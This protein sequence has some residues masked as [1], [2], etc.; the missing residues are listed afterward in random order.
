MTN[1]QC[2]TRT[3]IMSAVL[4]ILFSALL[5]PAWAQDAKQQD[6]NHTKKLP[7]ASEAEVKKVKDAMP[8]Q[9]AVTPKAKRRIL[10]FD[11]CEG[12]PHSCIPLATATFKIMGEKTGAFQADSAS[13][14]KVFTK[15]NLAKYDAVLF[16]NTTH[17]KF[18]D[19]A[20]REALMAFIKGGKGIIGIHA[21]TDNFYN[22]PEAAAMMGGVFD[23]HPW[24]AGGT[25]AFKLDDPEHELN[26]PFKGEGFTLSD[27]IYQ[28]KGPYT[29][30]NLR[31]L[32]SL[33]MN[34]QVNYQVDQKGIHRKDMDFGVSW[35]RDF[36]KGRMF[37]CSLGHNHHVYWNKPVLEH[38]LR[39]IQWA[40]GD[41]EADATS[42]ND[43][44][45]ENM[46]RRGL[47]AFMGR[48]G[49]WKVV[50]DAMMHPRDPKL[51][52]PAKGDGTRGTAINGL[53]G[54][55]R[56]LVTKKHFGDVHAHVEFMVPEGS[57]SGV[58]LM[59]RY[60]V[61][62]LDSFGKE[63]PQFSDCG[64]IYQRWDNHRDPKGYEGIPPKVNAALEPGKWQTYDIYF[65]APRFDEEGKK[66][67]N[68]VFVRVEH[69]G[70][71]IHE[72]QE[73]TGPTRASLY[74]DEQP[75]GPLMLQ[76][77]HGPVAYRNV[78]MLPLESDGDNTDKQ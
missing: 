44:F 48:M 30:D 25:W 32:I 66:I 11:R 15:D 7:P 47:A 45:R 46:I 14:M 72:N 75:L 10:I 39:G 29:R 60:E 13:D 5:T 70:K 67:A 23:N 40:L 33:D 73:V 27:E 56:H 2:V 68:A 52:K 57:N 22:W 36:E 24:T 64:G 1:Q 12:F 49:D 62:I 17:L 8:D 54:A 69:N 16:N 74:Q 51:L 18:H 58:Y 35:I 34:E 76:G 41:L 53:N 50:G 71:V 9:P 63:D 31:V 38:Y 42:S 3:F 20:H 37:Y 19:K 59:G 77:D 26:T 65:K 4:L 43:L 78:R 21:A 6:V 28:I 55:A 61:Q